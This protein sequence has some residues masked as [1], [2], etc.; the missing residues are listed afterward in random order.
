M[1]YM[2]I[3]FPGDVRDAQV[4]SRRNISD[5]ERWLSLAAGLGLAAYGLVGKRGTGAGLGIAALGGM[6]VK[7]GATAH[8]DAYHLMGIN[9]ANTSADTRSAL[10]GRAG[11]HVD[12]S[13]TINQP[14]EILYRFWRNL[15]NL[16]RFMRHLESVERVTDTLSRW[17]AK[18]PAGYT[19]EWNAEIINE[20]PNQ[21]IGWR[22]IEGSDVVSAGS[23][24]F[25]DAGPGRGTRV[26][27]RLQYS[28][29]GGKLG[30]A[31]A[32][33]LGRDPGS[34]IREDLRQ[35]KQILETGEVPTTA[36]QPRG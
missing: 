29:P 8:C 25:D 17:R 21:V 19:I 36:G 9:T 34:E 18:G 14:V 30:A 2:D 15:E 23:V 22:S 13:V 6:L 4:R 5:A 28:P 26:R 3:E 27:V 12:E 35:F 7:R 33:L 20:V 10:G 24:N 16:P 31:V 32:K 11:L 1:T